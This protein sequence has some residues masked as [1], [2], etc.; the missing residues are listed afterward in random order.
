MTNGDGIFAD[1]NLFN[2]E[3]D[4][5]L[6]FN[7]TKGFRSATQASQESCEGFCQSQE[8]SA[9]V[10]LIGDCLQLSPECLLALTQPRHAIAQ[11]LDRQELFLIG[12]EQSFHAFAN[13]G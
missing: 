12:V 3:S 2:Q 6:A 1:Q 11:L 9:I 7:D 5:S 4:D 13:L 8:D 10:S